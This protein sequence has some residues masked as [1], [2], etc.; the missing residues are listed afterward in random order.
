MRCGRQYAHPADLDR[1]PAAGSARPQQAGTVVTHHALLEHVWGPEYVYDTHYLKVFVRRLRQKLGDNATS[2]LH[3][4]RVGD[5]LSLSCATIVI[6]GLYSPPLLSPAVCDLLFIVAAS[7]PYWANTPIVV[8]RIACRRSAIVCYCAS[9][10]S[11]QG[12]GKP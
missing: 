10:R 7:K 6:I 11:R 9:Y 3:S 4:D 1:V 12:N 2:T 8:A 5:W